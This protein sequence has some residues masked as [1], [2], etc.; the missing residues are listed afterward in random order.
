M[1][2][3]IGEFADAES[4]LALKDF[5]NSMDCYNYEFRKNASLALDPTFRSNY[6][7]N[8]RIQGV[9]DADAILLVGVNPRVEAPVLNARIL[10]ATRKYGT[11]VYVVGGGSDL[12][13]EYKHVGLSPSVLSQLSDG[14]HPFAAELKNAKMPMVIVGRDALTR[15]DSPAI[16]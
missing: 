8:S 15:T 10:K 16:L 5:L 7:F 13:Y 4:I 12:T 1:A 2:A 6:L 14:S 11:K 3:G 9:E